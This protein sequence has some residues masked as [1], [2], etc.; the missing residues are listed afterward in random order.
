MTSRIKIL[1]TFL[2]SGSPNSEKE[3]HDGQSPEL[4]LQTPFMAFRG[5]AG[6]G[7]LCLGLL[8]SLY[9]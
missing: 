5:S 4:H 7:V 1:K 3:H 2:E 8:L 9:P 6:I